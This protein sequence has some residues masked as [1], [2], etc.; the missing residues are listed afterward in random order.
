VRFFVIERAVALY[1]PKERGDSLAECSALDSY[2]FGAPPFL[3]ILLKMAASS[4]GSALS[5]RRWAFRAVGLH[6]RRAHWV[7]TGVGWG[8][9]MRCHEV[10]VVVAPSR[11]FVASVGDLGRLQML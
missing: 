10:W 2:V 9:W 11:Q 1:G 4:S 3:S 6:V 7:V 5:G 8:D